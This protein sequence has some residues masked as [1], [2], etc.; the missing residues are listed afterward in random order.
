LITVF[1]LVILASLGVFTTFA[2]TGDEPPSKESDADERAA[3]GEVFLI[4][5]DSL[6]GA[7]LTGSAVDASLLPALQAAM[8]QDFLEEIEP[9]NDAAQATPLGGSNVVALGYVYPN[10]DLDFYSFQASA[11]DRIY[12]A[13]MTSFSASASTDSFLEL[14]ASDGS[15]VLESDDNNGSF[16]GLSSTIAGAVIPADGL[17]YIKIRHSGTS[18]IRP[19][20]LH[21]Q[22]RSGAP[23]AETEPN[24]AL[25]GQPMPALGWVSGE[26]SS[27]AD[28]DIYAVDL[29]AGDT[30]Y[31]SLD[32]DPERD[33]VEWNGQLGLGVFN[34]FILVAND[35]GD[36]GYDSE[37]FFLTV[38]Q[39]GT[40]SILVSV[41]GGAGF[42]T[43][44]LSASVHP[45]AAG[46]CTTYTSTDVPQV[47]PDGP[48]MATSTLTIAGN[49]RIADLDVFVNLTHAN[50]PD[51][52]VTLVSPA[53]NENGLFTDVGSNTQ[54]VMGLG[55]DDEA[56][57]PIGAYTV[58]SGMD[59]QPEL[60]Y[61]LHWF[62]GEDAGG[63][64]TLV[65]RDDTAA[66]GGTLESWGVTICEPPA[67]PVCPVGTV[68]T[69]VFSSDFEADNGGFSHS[70]TADEWEW[71]QPVYAPL[72][73]CN[74]GS[75]CWKTDLD[76]TYDASSNQNLLSPSI[77]LSG[78]YGPVHLTW[79]QKY[80][81]ESA[82][83][84]HAF[85][86]VQE[87]GG[88]NPQRAWEFLD[89]TMTT[90]VGNPTETIQES[91]GW[92]AYSTDISSYA[93]QNIELRFGLDSDTTVQ[94][95]GLAIDDVTVT[96]CRGLPEISVEK[97]VGTDA[98]TCATTDSISVP[99]ASEV[100]YCY[101]VTNTGTLPLT[102]HTLVDSELGTVLNDFPY[103]LAPEASA[104]LTQT[105]FI[106]Q[107]TVNTATWTAFNPG[108]IDETTATDTATVNV[109]TPVPEI[110]V[111]KT[112]GTDANICAATD[113]I[114][115]PAGTDVTYCYEVTN[116]GTV[117]LTRHTLLDSELGTLL[118]DFSYSL[119]PGASAFLTNT[120][121]IT[122]TTVNTATWTAFNPGPTDVVTATDSATVNVVQLG[123]AISLVKTVGTEPGMC[124][125]TTEITVP[126]GTQVY[127]CYEVTNTG[128]VTL[129]LHDLADDRLD[130][131][132]TGL[133]Y[134]LAPGAS[135]DTVTAGLSISETVT[136]T[137]TNTATWT[138]YNP[139][140]A[141]D[142]TAT[143]SA[144][145]YVT[146]GLFKLYLPV[147]FKSW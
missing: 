82:S 139:G 51:L 101:E 3:P 8:G 7:P 27:A 137:I 81:V 76:N 97:T 19:Y 145:V 112:V 102:R 99:G 104:F 25:P 62:D 74:S 118:N 53:G 24:D 79:A 50:M 124:A 77:D 119:A 69:I 6:G 57:L 142:A 108:P 23:V 29:N 122:Q 117:T 75:S 47:I 41:P 66:N 123:P 40:Y 78:Y 48:G 70:G 15:T 21:F 116:T 18:Q 71:G 95:A 88:G 45:A 135:I 56:D 36:A 16:G 136:A 4:P 72:T 141:D 85:L 2:Q 17:Y 96:A 38:Q 20:H 60:S 65:V 22:L 93:G 68:E 10:G 9:N 144:T 91:A 89:A 126:Q 140:P 105:V 67:P 12:A 61:R 113:S 115:V 32:L 121:N 37:A 114:A 98:N 42:G 147:S 146:D 63:T 128:S 143:A 30:I 134:D 59:Y 87:V 73:G 84:D 33:A 132:F 26:T 90:S 54:T 133:A 35:A 106:T 120:V 52:D 14:I 64:W 109:V 80:Q 11:G 13:A 39:S 103:T 34:G 28:I 55:L 83:F 125:A 92:G 107:T 44:H 111:D 100:T 58:M 131:L 46:A 129:T 110:S 127:Y 86:D 130:A 138:A 1:L 49:P 5:A 31:L 94:L 43:Y